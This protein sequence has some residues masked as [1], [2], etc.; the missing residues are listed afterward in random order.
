MKKRNPTLISWLV[1]VAFL[2]SCG[3][4]PV[5]PT[6]PVLTPVST[7]MAMLR[8]TPA[9]GPTA[10]RD[11]FAGSYPCSGVDLVSVLDRAAIGAADGNVNDMWG[12]TDPQTG[13]EWALVGH[14]RGTSFIDLSNPEAPVYAGT[15][16]LTPGARPSIWRDLKVY[17]DHVFIVSDVAGRHGMQVFD[18]TQLRDVASPPVTFAPSFLYDRIHS[19]HNIVINEETG[20]A[21][22]VGGSG[23]G[24]TCG[25]GLHMID[26]RSPRAP[27]FAGCF[28][29]R[30]TGNVGT[31]YTHDAMCVIYRGPH[32]R[33]RGREICF[34]SNETAL[35]IADVTDKSRP[36]ALSGATYPN[37]RYAH[38][39]WLDDAH[40][41]LYMGDER[42]ESGP[43]SR[44]RTI[45]WDVRSLDDPIV[46]NEYLATTTETDHNLYIVGDRMYQANYEAGLRIVSIEDR[47]RPSE[48]G[49][50]DMEPDPNARG[51]A[52]S[53]YPFFASGVIAVTEFN[54]GVFFVRVRG[55]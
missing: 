46:A 55:R 48:T 22:S 35:S 51:G 40:E 15:L 2:T 53:N 13:V 38:Q 21:Y 47:E 44:T 11:G 23:G 3:D 27:R 4:E 19:A 25:G 41:Y 36:V 5:I 52:W 50:F 29:D 8:S 7:N 39:A 30:S 6:E 34:G 10:C 31:G 16:P 18:L 26:V 17:R 45:V 49:F 9:N 20:F 1:S 42:D 43:A 54:R 32:A 24:E 14:S 37:V 33:Y 12:W 28:A